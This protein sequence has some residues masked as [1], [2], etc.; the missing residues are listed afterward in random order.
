MDDN[1]KKK[2]KYKIKNWPKYNA[3]LKARGSLTVWCGEDIKE[4]WYNDG[5]G[6][7]G[8]PVVYSDLAIETALT[9]Q[10]VFKLPL[11][12]TEGFVN[13]LFKL[14][15]VPL[16]CPNYS[17]LSRRR[18]TLDVTIQ[19]YVSKNEPLNIAIDSTGLKVFGEGE[20]KVRKHGV[21][22]RRTWRKLHLAVDVKS[23]QILAST[24][25][26]NDVHD[27]EV[28]G[29]LIAQ[30]DQPIDSCSA[31]GAYDTKPCYQT[32]H[33]KNITPKIP[34]Q[35]NAKCQS[36]GG[37]M[38][39][40]DDPALRP[41]DKAIRRIHELGNTDEARKTLKQEINYHDRSLSET[42][43]FRRKQL[44]SPKLSAR[45]FHNQ[46]TESNIIINALNKVTSLGMPDSLMIP[47]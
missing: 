21:G 35:R 38:G 3:A 30:I 4:G 42:A 10:A 39:A 46:I 9:L 12:A 19:Q 28:F 26:L 44:F 20:W 32:L 40:K 6:K 11:R 13:S 22:K 1:K 47:A 2:A 41:R 24:L 14:M 29:D 8:R 15:D 7:R 36:P 33:N 18:G 5:H 23:N 17:T 43:M 27:C 34:P 25:T 31:D 37:I 16:K 45:L